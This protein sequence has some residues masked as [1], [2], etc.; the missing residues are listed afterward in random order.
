MRLEVL[1][2]AIREAERFVRAANQA[3]RMAGVY[4]SEHLGREKHL[5]GGKWTAAAKR[6]S[7]DLARALVAVRRGS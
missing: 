6:A 3:K 7:M 5:N 4:Q 2:E 1:D